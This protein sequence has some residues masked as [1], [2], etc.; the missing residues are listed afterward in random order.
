[1]KD[2]EKMLRSFLKHDI[3]KSKYKIK[4]S[5]IPKSLFEAKKS[6]HKIVRTIALFIENQS[7]TAKKTATEIMAFLSNEL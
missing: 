7:S 5:E 2:K 6:N 4:E 1:M 3:I